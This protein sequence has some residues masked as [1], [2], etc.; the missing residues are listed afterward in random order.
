L[1]IDLAKC[2]Y[3]ASNKWDYVIQMTKWLRRQDSI[4]LQDLYLVW[5]L[6]LHSDLGGHNPGDPGTTDSPQSDSERDS[7]SASEG[8][9]K[10][11]RN[12]NP[13]TLHTDIVVHCLDC[14]VMVNNN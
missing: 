12:P 13:P 10:A 11:A 8:E 5:H 6:S 2:A 14:F 3:R 7:D 9:Y 4:Y 1:H